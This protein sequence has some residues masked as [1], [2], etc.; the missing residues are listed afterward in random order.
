MMMRARYGCLLAVTSLAFVAGCMRGAAQPPRAVASSSGPSAFPFAVSSP[1]ES[2]DPELPPVAFERAYEEAID[3]DYENSACALNTTTQNGFDY[4][5]M[6]YVRGRPYARVDA[7]GKIVGVWLGVDEGSLFAKGTFSTE[8][9]SVGGDLYLPDLR[10]YATVPIVLDGWIHVVRTR[11]ATKTSVKGPFFA[12]DVKLPPGVHLRA[13][14][15]EDTLRVPCAF[16]S[17]SPP[18]EAS[19]F[20]R[21]TSTAILDAPEKT[22]SISL[23]PTGAPV[24]DITKPKELNLNLVTLY[25]TTALVGVKATTKESEVILVGWIHE[26]EL[27]DGYGGL[28]SGAVGTI[29]RSDG[30]SSWDCNGVSVFVEADRKLFKVADVN[31]H[32]D[33][34][35]ALAPNG[36]LRVD[37]GANPSWSPTAAPKKGPKEPLDA[38]VP[39]EFLGRCKQSK[40]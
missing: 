11:I 13:P 30:A 10:L 28:E 2:A 32:M 38:F 36:D 17:T 1:S 40:S 21:A 16:V 12:P 31:D 33:F 18:E 7:F 19:A 4:D 23:T 14:L 39:K 37:L 24:A 3:T 8:H 5:G 35:G 9:A 26:G 15:R 34:R 27:N 29:G 20:D 25:K 22:V 6:L